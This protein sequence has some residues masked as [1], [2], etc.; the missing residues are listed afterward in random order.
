MTVRRGPSVL[1]NALPFASSD[2]TSKSRH[3]AIF[4][5]FVKSRYVQPIR[6]QESHVMQSPDEME[7]SDWL[8][9]S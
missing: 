7:R 1:M 5:N 6:S 9:E 2:F 3:E 4:K 8:H